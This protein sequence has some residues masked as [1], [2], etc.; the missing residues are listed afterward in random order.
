MVAASCGDEGKA[1]SVLEELLAKEEY[2]KAFKTSTQL[3]LSL[4]QTEALVFSALQTGRWESARAAIRR[5]RQQQ[6]QK[7]SSGEDSAAAHTPPPLALEE[8]YCLYRLNKPQKALQ[9][10]AELQRQPQ[11]HNAMALTHL[12]AQVDLLVSNYLASAACMLE[13]EAAIDGSSTSSSS[14]SF[15]PAVVEALRGNCGG[16]DTFE[17]P[18]N[19]ACLYMQQKKSEAAAALLQ[20]ALDLCAAEAGVSQSAA[21]Q[22]L[23]EGELAGVWVQHGVLQQQQGNAEAAEEVY[24]AVLAVL[25][26]QQQQQQQQE[27]DVGVAAVAVTNAYVLSLAR[28]ELPDK[29]DLEGLIR[30]TTKGA[31]EALDHKL[32][33]PQALKIGVNRCLGLLRSGRIEDCRRLT[34]SLTSR[35]GG[36]ASLQRIKAAV[37]VRWPL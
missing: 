8:A 12:H 3:P 35:F 28:R 19:A 1:F 29:Q 26:Q 7:E 4:K 20:R 14:L 30:R 17:L 21:L 37:Q 9:L 11:T 23:D 5:L 6:Q 15:P 16:S 33:V 22:H 24:A 2:D 36:C 18:F 27:I 34:V 25:E 13:S 31:T 10:L 32:T